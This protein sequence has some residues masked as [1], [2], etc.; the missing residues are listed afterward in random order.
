MYC[1]IDITSS[2]K[3][4]YLN[5]SS[6]VRS[7]G[8]SPRSPTPNCVFYTQITTRE[9][10]KKNHYNQH[11]HA[12]R[13][14]ANAQH[15]NAEDEEQRPT[16]DQKCELITG[17]QRRRRRTAE[18]PITLPWAAQK[19]HHQYNNTTI[20]TTAQTPRWAWTLLLAGW[21]LLLVTDPP[22]WDEETCTKYNVY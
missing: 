17:G 13:A 1:C 8:R 6:P 10:H 22:K 4:K 18:G 16:N 3:V 12:V 11:G 19:R 5:S 15:H 20:T 9:R 14:N 21:L 7:F 2:S